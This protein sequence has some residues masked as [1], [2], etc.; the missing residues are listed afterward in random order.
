MELNLKNK[1]ALVTASGRGI[2]RAI[3]LSLAKEGCKVAV[4]ARTESN[5]ENVLKEMGKTKK[6]HF[7]VALDLTKEGAPQKLVKA[8]QKDFGLP[9]IVVHNLGG[10][11]GITDPFCSLQDWRRM[12]RFNFEVAVELNIA[13]IPPMVKKKWGRVVHISSLPVWKI[14]GP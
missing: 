14:R 6:G 2:G 8:L 13:L 11:L 4:V 12:Y 10:T 3:A 5:I 1:L 9:G 7:G